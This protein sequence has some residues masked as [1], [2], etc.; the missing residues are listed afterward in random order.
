[1]FRPE[2]LSNVSRN[3]SAQTPLYTLAFDF[4]NKKE[5][6]VSDYWVRFNEKIKKMLIIVFSFALLFGFAF[7]IANKIPLSDVAISSFES[8][9]R[10]AI[11]YSGKTYLS[12]SSL[13][14][15]DDDFLG[16]LSFFEDDPNVYALY[17][18][19]PESFWY[20]EGLCL[21]EDFV[22]P[23]VSTAP[24]SAIYFADS[25]NSYDGFSD[26]S[27]KL[28]AEKDIQSFLKAI[29]NDELDKWIKLI[30]EKNSINPDDSFDIVVSYKDLPIWQNIASV[31]NEKIVWKSKSVTL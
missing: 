4:D 23:N 3:S 11:I 1:M 15:D 12:V 19:E 7:V 13:F 29:K 8:T 20:E 27:V 16:S 18:V 26:Y 28:E 22:L 2:L 6:A 25:W 10:F 30:F 17:L 14:E 9:N 21:R 5:R 24:I 31:E